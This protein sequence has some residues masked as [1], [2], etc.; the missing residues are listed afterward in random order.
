MRDSDELQFADEETIAVDGKPVDAWKVLIVD[1]EE[2]VHRVTR[3]ALGNFSFEG[4]PLHL[5]SAYSGREAKE[6]IADHPD[7]AMILLDVVMEEDDAGL[8]FVRFLRSEQQ[9][10]MTRVVL[11]TGQPGQAPEQDVIVSYD[12]NDYRSKTELSRQK[13]FTTVVASLR[14]FRDLRRIA[15]AR[16][17]LEQALT[18]QRLLSEA[19]ARFVPHELLRILNK[20]GIQDVQLGEN[21]DRVMAIMVTD[22]RGFAAIA[23]RMTPQENFDFINE[24]FGRTGPLIRIN[25]GFVLKYMG[26]GMMATFAN[27]ADDAV[28]AGIQI[29]ESVAEYNRAPKAAGDE[30]IQV[31]IGVHVGPMRLGIV[32]ETGRIQGDAFSDEVNLATRLEGLTR[33]YNV[34]FLVSDAA[35]RALH[36]PSRF[37][38][39]AMATTRVRGKEKSISIHECFDADSPEQRDLKKSTRGVFEEAVERFRG[40]DYWDAGRLFKQVQAAN[41]SDQAA[42]YYLRRTAEQLAN[43]SK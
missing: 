8:R 15:E 19:A 12:I 21:A 13:L 24:H 31:G 18:A 4:R 28:R 34:P 10:Y 29:L 37:C 23:E 5:M 17:T 26:D 20:R 25:G 1:D 6:V 43:P 22:I 27:G 42:T 11:R 36:D 39:R 14:S 40:E 3:L 33:D 41:P 16:A 2:E 32:G 38:L 35:V 9:N 7:T 30:P